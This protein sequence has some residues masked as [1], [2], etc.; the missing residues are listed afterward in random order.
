MALRPTL[1]NEDA[2]R[3]GEHSANRGGA[4]ATEREVAVLPDL[5]R[6]QSQPASGQSLKPVA[7]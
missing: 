3:L 5:M 7:L 4:S 2:L 1:G 6:T